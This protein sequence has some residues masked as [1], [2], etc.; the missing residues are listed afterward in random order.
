MNAKAFSYLDV[1][2]ALSPYIHYDCFNYQSINRASKLDV[3]VIDMLHL[4]Y[5]VFDS[6][7]VSLLWLGW[8]IMEFQ[9]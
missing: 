7:M 4:S 6:A 2:L 8:I 9:S 1:S 5:D 3:Q